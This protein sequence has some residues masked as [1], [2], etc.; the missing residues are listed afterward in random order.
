MARKMFFIICFLLVHAA[1]GQLVPEWMLV[2]PSEKQIEGFGMG[3][4]NIST[5]S[6]KSLKDYFQLT[7]TLEFFDNQQ[8]VVRVKG[9]DFQFNVRMQRDSAIVSVGDKQRLIVESNIPPYPLWQYDYSEMNHRE[10]ASLSQ[11]LREMPYD[12]L[13]LRQGFQ[14]C[15]SYALE[16]IFLSHGIDP[17]PFFF[18][19]SVPASYDDFESI[20]ENLFIKVETLGNVRKRT[21]R[22]SEYLHEDQVFILFRNTLGEPM[23]ACFNLNGRTWTKNGMSP[24]T[25]HLTPYPVID[26]YNSKKK[27]RYNSSDLHKEFMTIRSVVGIEIYQLNVDMFE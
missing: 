8:D 1:Q 18:R 6:D 24:Y 16:G 7:D 27:I 4:I 21:L 23:H 11:E 2:D 15:V 22:R 13:V 9:L 12:T 5:P 10:L 19:R 14:T 26:S 20:L 17:E 3:K 25:S